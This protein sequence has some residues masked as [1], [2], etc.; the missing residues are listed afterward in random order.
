MRADNTAHLIIA[1]SRRHE[2]ARSKAI[3]ALRE[4][5]DTG[6]TVSFE[7]VAQTAEVSRSR[8]YTQPNIGPRSNGSA[9][10]TA[11]P[12]T[13]QCQPATAAATHPVTPAGS[14]QRTLDRPRLDARTLQVHWTGRTRHRDWGRRRATTHGGR[15]PVSGPYLTR[16]T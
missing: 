3:R 4:L 16:S 2:L 6:A 9:T 8:L 5:D 1:A 12:P 14:Q 7:V 13:R 10:S 15:C 11:D